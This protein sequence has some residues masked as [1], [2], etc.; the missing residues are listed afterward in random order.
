MVVT[1]AAAAV[2][3]AVAVAEFIFGAFVPIG[4]RGCIAAS[5]DGSS[6]VLDDDAGANTVVVLVLLSG[7][8][9]E[10][11]SC[12]RAQSRDAAA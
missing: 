7:S 1:A 6:I 11:L 9:S 3:V 5:C 10:E 2:A 8:L 4:S 12:G